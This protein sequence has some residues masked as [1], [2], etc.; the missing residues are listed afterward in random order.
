MPESVIGRRQADSF[1]GGLS[2]G[3]I[4][5]ESQF[6]SAF[7]KRSEPQRFHA[8]VINNVRERRKAELFVYQGPTRR[9]VIGA[10]RVVMLEPEVIQP[11]ASTRVQLA[12][13]ERF[14]QMHPKLHERALALA[15][16][17]QAARLLADKRK[18]GIAI[19]DERRER[20]VAQLLTEALARV[21]AAEAARI[22]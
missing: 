10:D 5:Q 9:G 21:E 16:D 3:E 13:I 11:E 2:Y 19:L 15:Q 6:V 20:H 1:H 8:P 4:S 17:E 22:S 14:Q 7:A 12:P 18:S